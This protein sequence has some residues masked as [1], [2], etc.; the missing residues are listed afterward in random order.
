MTCLLYPV[1]VVKGLP[2]GWEWT[3]ASSICV[4]VIWVLVQRKAT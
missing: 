1:Q 4:A 3:A 2:G